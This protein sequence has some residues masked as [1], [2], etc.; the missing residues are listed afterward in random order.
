MQDGEVPT[1][2]RPGQGER[3]GIGAATLSRHPLMAS[4]R[5]CK[6]M[7][8]AFPKSVACRHLSNQH[9]MPEGVVSGLQLPD[10]IQRS[11]DHEL[12]QSFAYSKADG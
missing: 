10:T 6:K 12:S 9:T 4:E 11:Q 3:P 5:K 8:H 1:Y 2:C 7:L